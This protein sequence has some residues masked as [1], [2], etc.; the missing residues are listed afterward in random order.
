MIEEPDYRSVEPGSGFE[1]FIE[2]F[3]VQTGEEEAP[4]EVVDIDVF[5]EPLAVVDPEIAELVGAEL[6]R[7][8]ATLD[9]VASENVT[10]RAVLET[11]GSVLTAKYADGYPGARDY[12]TCEVVDAVESLAIERAKSLFGA[13]H[14]NVQPYSG[15]SANQAVLRAL[16]QPGDV[17]LGFD[18]RHGGHSTHHHPDTVAGRYYKTFTYGVRQSDRRV[19]MEQVQALAREHRPRVVFAGWSCYPRFLDFRAFRQICDEVGAYLVVDMAHFAGLVAAGVHPSPVGW[20]DACTMT[21]H[22]T[23]GGARGGAII[24]SPG[25][26]A[27]VD[28]AVYPG[29]QGCPLL[30]VIAAK[31]VTFA[32]AATSAYRER[33]ERTVSGART[34]AAALAEAGPSIGLEVVTGG[35]DVHQ[36]LV[37]LGPSGR[38][39]KAELA[40]LNSIGISANAVPLAYDSLELP[41]VSGLRFGTPALASRGFGPAEFAEV[42]AILTAALGPTSGGDLELLAERVGRLAEEWPIYPYLDSGSAPEDGQL[43]PDEG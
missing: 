5:R 29:E 10:P 13:G 1:D 33:I 11:Q 19:D 15:S 14:A 36:V 28:A 17:V 35:T 3:T 27:R 30:H 9:L 41:L 24:C 18:A 40:R 42:G 8:R 32:V 4:G 21:V 34:I 25:L 31:A 6:A 43:L 7:Q 16:C 38:E 12:D 2:G 20:A 23:L 26:A 39:G 37:D 22:K